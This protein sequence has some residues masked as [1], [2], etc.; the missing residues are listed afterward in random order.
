[1]NFTNSGIYELSAPFELFLKEEKIDHDAIGDFDIVAETVYSAIS[2]GTEIAAYAGVEPLRKGNLY[3]RVIGYC[4][5]AVVTHTGS[6]VTSV[7]VGDH[8]L[9][10]QS[11]RTAFKITE[12]DFFIQL[13]KDS[14]LKHA[15]TA[16]LYHLGY[17]GLITADAKAG[18]NI[19]VIGLG[20][21]GYTT[22]MMSKNAGANTYC[23]TNQKKPIE[24]L[25]SP[26]VKCYL[27][28]EASIYEI[29]N[30]TNGTGLDIVINTSNKWEDWLLALQ[31]V[32]KGGTI[33][34]TGFPGRGEPAPS[35]NP[36]DPQYVYVKNI[37]VKA[38]SYINET[39]TAA[40]EYRFNVKRNLV[41]ILGLIKDGRLNAA[42]L[43]SAQIG[44]ESLA[45][46]YKA[47]LNRDAFILTTLIH[48]KK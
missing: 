38:L 25:Q 20:T 40:H 11:H 45:A 36:L 6:K 12:Q 41:Y 33:V 4:N 43:I 34:N 19:G 8:I 31:A 48:W 22:C 18:H 1:M 30:A 15:A 21:L 24:L 2:P 42:E 5:V 23:F 14:N 26:G 13:D 44:Y 9:T 28:S 7:V 27:K 47:Y 10:F 3:P 16:Y 46:Q 29:A 39:G 17:H 35:F 37:T 32:A